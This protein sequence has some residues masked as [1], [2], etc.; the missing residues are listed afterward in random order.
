[1][2]GGGG[3][4][5]HYDG[6]SGGAGNANALFGGGGFMPSQ[7]T[8]VPENS[9][10]SKGRSA[11]TLLP[12]TVKQ[13]MDAAQTSGDRSNFAIN[14][15]EVSTIRLVGRM[16]GKVERVTDVVFTLDDGTGKI[17]VNRWENEASDAKEMADANNENYV[18][19]IG[20][21]KGFQGKR[22]VV[23]YAVRRVT[24]FN[25]I[26][27]HFLH[28]I[29]VHMELTGLKIY[30]SAATYGGVAHAPSQPNPVDGNYISNLVLSVFHDP[31]VMDQEHG[32]HI[33]DVIDRLKLPD[34]VVSAAIQGHVDVGNIYNTIDDFHYKS[35]RNG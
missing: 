15:V 28:C 8:V 29:Q 6:G 9:G 11:Q 4:G 3:G 26:T 19:V 32:L 25:E 21:L 5:G 14:G 7:S 23:A 20:G 33:K 27:C 12:L 13:T 30:S 1:M 34:D 35:V 2:Y 16:L 18:I 31:S 24:N 17:D 10:L 22:H